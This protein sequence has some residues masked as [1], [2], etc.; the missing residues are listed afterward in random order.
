MSER[1]SYKDAGVDIA[2]GDA[3]VTTVAALAGRT[4]GNGVV[5]HPSSYAGLFR[6]NLEGVRDPLIAATCDG[7]GTKLLVAHAAKH[8][9]GLGQD[10][11]AMSVNDLLP[12]GARPLLFLDY[13]A[14][15]K[16]DP[17]PLAEVVAGVADA[18]ASVGCAL[19]GGETAEMP[20]VYPPGE[21][22]L[23]GFAVGVADGSRLPNPEEVAP[24]H[25]VL[26]LPSSGIHSN[27]LSL[28][29][30]ALEA[31]GLGVHDVVAALG[32][33]VGEELL[34]PTALYVDPVLALF[35]HA[36]FSAAAHVTGGGL[37]GRGDKLL[38]DGQR[39]VLD[40]GSFEVPAIFDLIAEAGGVAEEEMR[41]AFNM[42]LGFLAVLSPRAAEIALE[43][44]G[45]PWRRVGRIEAGTR[46]VEIE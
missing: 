13:V 25:V 28:A 9:R 36:P 19:I 5:K 41:R 39:L 4:H 8:Y 34:E 32:R 42:G 31:G 27:G 15:G 11:V 6:P 37:I 14:T 33:T 1:L 3:F 21:F 16:L 26:G 35:E 20:G 29:R 30:K 2:A 38:R 18:C 7:V 45:E 43:V 17:A 23:A 46:G 24:G 22:D 40:S 10:L 12:L 44:V